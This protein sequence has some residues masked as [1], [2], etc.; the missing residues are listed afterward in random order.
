MKRKTLGFLALSVSA[1]LVLQTP[2]TAM[3]ESWVN[4]EIEEA[5]EGTSEYEH[6]G[7]VVV[8]GLLDSAVVA[9]KEGDKLKINGNV[10]STNE[11]ELTDENN[12]NY[13]PSPVYA[14]NGAEIT[15]TGDV[16]A[17][18]APAIVAG[19]ETGKPGGKVFVGGDVSSN[20]NSAAIADVSGSSITINGD[21][22]S[23]SGSAVVAYGGGSVT[24]GGDVKSNSEEAPAVNADNN[25]TVDIKGNVSGVNGGI[26]SSNSSKVNVDKGVSASSGV[27][28]YADNSNVTV[29]GDV[30]STPIS[31]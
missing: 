22:T 28:I 21:A 5:G 27:A 4:D 31:K 15:I 7:N 18:K 16:S 19:A 24:V 25:G 6:T 8:T 14:G 12:D 1:L 3:A 2:T 9:D 30:T 10:T 29:G 13:F 26:Y 20:E 23:K 17:E 11:S